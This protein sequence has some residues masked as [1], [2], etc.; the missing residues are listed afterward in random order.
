MRQVQPAR[1]VHNGEAGAAGDS[2]RQESKQANM[3]QAGYSMLTG[4]LN[5]EYSVERNQQTAMQNQIQHG[6]ACEWAENF[7]GQAR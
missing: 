1:Y 7:S 6:K 5:T 3:Q 2:C 4:C